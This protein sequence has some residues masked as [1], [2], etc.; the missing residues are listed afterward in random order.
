M[1]YPLLRGTIAAILILIALDINTVITFVNRIIPIT[2]SIDLPL[3]AKAL[4]G[5]SGILV[6]GPTDVVKAFDTQ[7]NIDLENFRKNTQH[8]SKTGFLTEFKE[9]FQWLIDLVYP[10]S[11]LVVIIDDLDRCLP[12]VA[13]EI[14]EAIKLF[15]DV[16]RCVFVLGINKELIADAIHV[17]YRELLENKTSLSDNQSNP[18]GRAVIGF[19]NTYLDR[20]VQHAF[21]IPPMDE[22]TKCHFIESLLP[23]EHNTDEVV[24]VLVQGLEANPRKIKQAVHLYLMWMDLHEKLD[25]INKETVQK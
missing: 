1:I 14:L 13:V 23:K 10:R 2:A 20:I 22:V 17:R 12:E 24:E 7:L 4:L 8:R 9:N 16:D 25:E 19:G 15:L 3:Y 21:T 11:P 6:L 18:V 5:I